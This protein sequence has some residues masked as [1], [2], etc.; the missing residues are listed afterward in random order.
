ML[1]PVITTKFFP[2]LNCSKV[3]SS[4]VAFHSSLTG[5]GQDFDLLVCYPG[6]ASLTRIQSF[7]HSFACTLWIGTSQYFTLVT[8]ESLR[9]ADKLALHRQ[10]YQSA[11]R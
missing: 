1:P 5:E 6:Q 10:E 4:L 9:N 7:P 3:P 11:Q 8:T 2:T